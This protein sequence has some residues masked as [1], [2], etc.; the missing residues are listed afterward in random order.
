MEMQRLEASRDFQGAQ[1]E[2]LL[3][4][5]LCHI[6]IVRVDNQLVIQVYGLGRTI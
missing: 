4:D 2:Q 1:L 3:E 6:I 5:G